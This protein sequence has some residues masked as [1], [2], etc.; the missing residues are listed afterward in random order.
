MPKKRPDRDALDDTLEIW[1]REIPDLDPLTEG[2][3]ER[4]QDLA[5]NV[6]Q[7]MDETLKKY[8]LDRRSFHLLGRLRRHGPP[9]RVAAGK[10]SDELRLSTGAMTNRLDR[11]EKAGL[12]R[13]L[14]DPTDR[15]ATLIEPT[16]AGHAAWDRTVGL[17][18]RREAEYIGVLSPVEKVRLH[19]LL[20]A[21]M[22]AFPDDKHRKHE[23][24]DAEPH[25][26]EA[27]TP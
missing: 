8:E 17:Q 11:M 6:N 20:R 5:F 2:I 10:L 14:P 22:R 25:A 7:S 9:Y 21:L 18:A 24:H 27:P 19:D 13:R 23:S 16:E 1:A 12:I 26:D 15:R 4:I 3:I